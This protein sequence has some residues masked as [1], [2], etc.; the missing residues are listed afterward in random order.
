M[1]SPTKRRSTSTA[2]VDDTSN[3]GAAAFQEGQMK[4]CIRCGEQKPISEFYRHPQMADGHLNKC[5]G[6][7]KEQAGEYSRTE[8]GKE[9]DRRRN[10]KAG[11]R[12][13][14][15]GATRRG[16]EK[17]PDHYKANQAVA[18]ALRAGRLQ[19]KPCAV[20]GTNR[21]DGHHEDYARPLE[22]IWLCRRHHRDLHNRRG[23]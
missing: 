6:C 19:K 22:V 20:C 5:K 7:C 23:R 18:H 12:A 3:C 16:R 8:R 11:R 13:W 10:K 9:M 4:P 21:V 1:R 2:P 17:H 15:A 14:M